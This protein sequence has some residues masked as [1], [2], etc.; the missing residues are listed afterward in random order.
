[1]SWNRYNL[2]HKKNNNKKIARTKICGIY[3]VNVQKL[4]YGLEKHPLRYIN[5]NPTFKNN[6]KIVV[7]SSIQVDV[8]L[9]L[10]QTMNAN[11]NL[12]I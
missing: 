2:I 11:L 12:L 9:F 1:M 8:L 5:I 10:F 6:L 4:S 3:I 7:A